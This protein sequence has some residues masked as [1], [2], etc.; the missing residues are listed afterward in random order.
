[1]RRWRYTKITRELKHTTATCDLCSNERRSNAIVQLWPPVSLLLSLDAFMRGT[2]VPS[3]YV[4]WKMLPQENL[5]YTQ[6]LLAY[7][8]K[9]LKTSVTWNYIIKQFLH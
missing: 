7:F 3:V 4:K 1:M 9:N 5:E 6:K 8:L 2:K